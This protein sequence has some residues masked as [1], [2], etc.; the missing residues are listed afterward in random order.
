MYI[1]T[2]ELKIIGFSVSTLQKLVQKNSGIRK[3]NTLDYFCIYIVMEDL[4]MEVEDIP[5]Q[6]KPHHI[7]FIGPEKKVFFKESIGDQIYVISFSSSFYERSSKDS[8]FLNSHLFFNYSSDIFVA[9]FNNPEEKKVLFIKRMKHFQLVDESLYISA[10]HNA[11]ESL[12][13]DAFLYANSTEI[14]KDVKFDYLYYVNRFKVLLQRC[15]K[16]EKKVSYYAGQLHVSSRKLT[17]MTEYILGKTAKQVVIEKIT[18]ECIKALESSNQTISEIS[19][20][21]GFSNEANFTNFIKKHTG[22]K[23]SEIKSI[24]IV[25]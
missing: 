3:F 12:I 21:L 22:K 24:T 19:Y 14:N 23:P 7:I 8:L 13:L 2:D 9:P 25:L 11:I 15:F 18:S 20:D 10:A 1:V 4:T 5:Y 17:E 6:I 16:T